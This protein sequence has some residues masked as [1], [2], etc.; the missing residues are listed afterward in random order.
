MTVLTDPRT[1]ITPATIARRPYLTPY[2]EPG[3]G[4]TL[5]R[6]CGDTGSATAPF[7]PTWNIDA[8]HHYS[9]D[10]PWNADGTLVKLEQRGGKPGD[11]IVDGRT[12][13]P[14]MGDIGIFGQC[15]ETRWHPLQPNVM[16]GWI[17]SVG[18]VVVFNP[19]TNVEIHRVH[20]G[21]TTISP[22][23][24]GALSEDGNML[25]LGD[26]ASNALV[27]DIANSRVGPLTKIVYPGD[28]AW[29]LNNL[30]M[31]P[32]STS[33]GGYVVFGGDSDKGMVCSYGGAD[34]A[35]V[36]PRAFSL[37]MSH[38][39][40]GVS[41]A[42]REVYVGG[43]RA[44]YG[45]GTFTNKDGRII[46][47]DIATGAFTHVSMGTNQLGAIGKE[48]GDQHCS[49]RGPRGWVLTTYAGPQEGGGQFCMELVAWKLD[50]SRECVRFGVTRTNEAGIYRAEA[51]GVMRRDGKAVMFA[52]NNQWATPGIL[53][54]PNDIK[55]HVY[56]LDSVTPPPSTQDRF[57]VDPAFTYQP[58]GAVFD[59]A[60]GRIVPLPEVARLLN[61]AKW[62]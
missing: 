27:V 1:V 61:T 17:K 55:A 12:W 31:S 18:D 14:I 51:H 44:Y 40:V 7:I 4:S 54:D 59:H 5:V 34:L 16:V 45:S 42:G 15:Y 30:T 38:A 49:C 46:S 57:Y 39:D 29:T 11:F 58:P 35:L 20:I 43:A 2:L 3:F 8:R 9:K 50:G 21:N 37:A 13:H 32:L 41:P 22:M 47:I 26:T 53:G 36:M 6:I 24:E 10:Q 56:V 62:S 23:G 19:I 52:S 60:T 28:P 25:A 48:S 33:A